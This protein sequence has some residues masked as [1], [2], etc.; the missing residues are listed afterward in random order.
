MIK[1]R[2]T[3]I[4]LLRLTD[5]LEEASDTETSKTFFRIIYEPYK[6]QH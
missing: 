2:D 5:A 1:K 3:V 4:M 6:L